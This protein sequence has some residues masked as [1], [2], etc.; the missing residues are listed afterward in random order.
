MWWES[1]AFA[2]AT[3]ETQPA[4]A[5]VPRG[6]RVKGH[7]SSSHPPVLPVPPVG[8]RELEPADCVKSDPGIIE[9]NGGVG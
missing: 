8:Q 7:L 6:Q 3:E 9:L 4:T 1:L 5:E 2:G